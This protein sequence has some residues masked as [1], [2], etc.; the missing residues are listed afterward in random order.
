MISTPE[1]LFLLYRSA[2]AQVQGEYSAFLR[3]FVEQRR[4]AQ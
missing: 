2:L 3:P 4:N 1:L